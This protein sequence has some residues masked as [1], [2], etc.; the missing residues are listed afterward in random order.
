[1][2]APDPAAALAWYSDKFGG[3][4][5]KLK[6]RIDGINYGGVWLLAQKGE[7]TPSAGHAI[8][9]IGMRP[10]NV[11]NAVAELKKKSVK[12]TTEPRPLTLPSGVSMRLAF[13][14]GP[15]GARIELVQR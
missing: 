2:R 3:P 9:H 15:E 12:V 6:D 5:G 7:A 13:I 1:L 4:I 10:L 8:D 11:D 14:E